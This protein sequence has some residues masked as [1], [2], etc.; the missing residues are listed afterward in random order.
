MFKVFHVEHLLVLISFKSKKG[1]EPHPNET[2][3]KHRVGR[4]SIRGNLFQ[5]KRTFAY[6]ITFLVNF[7]CI[8]TYSK[9]T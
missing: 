1:W 6:Q 5:I 8:M 7:G 3:P 9:R 4:G 2:P